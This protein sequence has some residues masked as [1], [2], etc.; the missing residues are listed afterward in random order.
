M[1]KK[2]FSAISLGAIL[3]MAFVLVQPIQVSAQSTMSNQEIIEMIEAQAGDLTLEEEDAINEYLN[4][5]RSMGSNGGTEAT[6]I[7]AQGNPSFNG[8]ISELTLPI[9]AFL[10]F[11]LQPEDAVSMVTIKSGNIAKTIHAEKEIFHCFTEQGGVPLVVEMTV[12]AE[13]YE[14]LNTMEIIRKQVEVVTCTKL[15]DTAKVIG[16]ETDSVPTDVV[17]LTGCYDQ[18]IVLIIGSFLPITLDLLPNHP[19]EMNAVNKGKIV[20]TI[21][22]QKEIFLCNLD[23][24]N[25]KDFGSVIFPTNEKKV[26]TV[27]FTEIWED[28]N[29]LPGDP[30]VKKTF[31][32]LTCVVSLLVDG[33]GDGS[34]DF[35]NPA[36][37]LVNVESCQFSSL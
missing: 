16:C 28:L 15:L 26:E 1:S 5:L 22:S 31:E 12:F 11:N 13:I 17:P 8:C 4:S 24:D 20:K 36:D 6:S 23:V 21:E 14:N 18:A 34:V 27:I 10:G 19:Q 32:S 7:T 37:M 2:M 25:D 3:L 30:V 29:L 9:L 33:D 35:D